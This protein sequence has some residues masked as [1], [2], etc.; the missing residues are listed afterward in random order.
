MER[1]G[2]KGWEGEAGEKGKVG[3]TGMKKGEEARGRGMSGEHWEE[4]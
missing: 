1:R 4:T 3:R 2:W